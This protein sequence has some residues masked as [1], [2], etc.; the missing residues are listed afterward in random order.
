MSA[1]DSSNDVKDGDIKN[2]NEMIL[3]K[4][5]NSRT[6][7]DKVAKS[8]STIS[9]IRNTDKDA[10]R[11]IITEE[12]VLDPAG[13]FKAMKYIENNNFLE[14][15]PEMV[16]SGSKSRRNEFSLTQPQQCAL[17]LSNNEMDSPVAS[18]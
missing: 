7:Q 10:A 18:S 6:E 16:K 4:N 3:N 2:N 8:T 1:E 9:G 14:F 13:M 12:N 15:A 11:K 17:E 5:L